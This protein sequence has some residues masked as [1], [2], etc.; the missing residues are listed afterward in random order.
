MEEGIINRSWWSFLL[1]GIVAIAFGIILLAWTGATVG[2]IIVLVGL[3]ALIDGVVNVILAVVRATRKEKWGWTLA[4]GLIGF[5]LGAVI[6]AHPEFTFEVVAVLVGIYAVAMG[7]AMLAFAFD[8]PAMSGR[9]WVGVLGALS[10]I[11]GIIILVYPFGSA[12]TVS[13]LVAIYALAV[14][15]FDIFLTFFALGRQR[16]VKKEV[17]AA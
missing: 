15:I 8:L 6:I 12:Y 11:I 7:I 17:G 16:K 13:V 4:A 10:I 5:L 14:G 3:L 2:T 9:G 1:R